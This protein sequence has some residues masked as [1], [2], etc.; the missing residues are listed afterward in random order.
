MGR[1]EYT[2]H[3]V[4]HHRLRSWS[5]SPDAMLRIGLRN[6]RGGLR[7]WDISAVLLKEKIEKCEHEISVSFLEWKSETIKLEN[8]AW[9]NK[10]LIW[11]CGRSR[12][13]L[14]PKF[15]EIGDFRGGNNT[16]GFPSTSNPK[17][18][19]RGWNGVV[20]QILKFLEYFTN[21]SACLHSPHF[22]LKCQ[23]ISEN[24]SGLLCIRNGICVWTEGLLG[25]G[26][27]PL[28]SEE[29]NLAC[30]KIWGNG[31]GLRKEST[32]QVLLSRNVFKLKFFLEQTPLYGLSYD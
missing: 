29:W 21:P 25:G 1:S 26:R 31:V 5:W 12:L 2:C 20:T 13:L 17:A 28:R 30:N 6:P 15:E 9:F 24:I 16:Q 7:T 23:G 19:R 8:I 3:P 18:R 4:H 14:L 32:A 11:L 10:K 27:I 22:S